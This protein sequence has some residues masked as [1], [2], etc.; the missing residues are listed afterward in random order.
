MEELLAPLMPLERDAFEKFH[1]DKRKPMSLNKALGLFDLF[2]NG[3]S[4]QEI[5]DT[6][7]ANLDLEQVVDRMCTL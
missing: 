2:L 1:N 6:D 3:Y 4:L 7:T 5:V